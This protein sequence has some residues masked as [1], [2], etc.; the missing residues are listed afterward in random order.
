[1]ENLEQKFGQNNNEDQEIKEAQ[2]IKERAEK[3]EKIERTEKDYL[4]KYKEYEKLMDTLRIRRRELNELNK[5]PS[6]FN[7]RK[8]KKTKEEIGIICEQINIFTNEL[9]QIFNELPEELKKKYLR[10]EAE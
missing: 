6:I 4:D 9:E 7:R 1:M 2:E 5:K 10:I 3:I 8:A